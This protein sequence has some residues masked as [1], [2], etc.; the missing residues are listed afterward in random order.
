MKAGVERFYT[1]P[2]ARQAKGCGLALNLQDQLT[3][4]VASTTPEQPAFDFAYIA[5]KT[6]LRHSGQ[7]SN[8]TTLIGREVPPCR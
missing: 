2:F 8:V 4:M 7:C 1:A 3:R 6:R 5:S